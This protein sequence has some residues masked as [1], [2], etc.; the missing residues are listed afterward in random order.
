MLF[1]W[2]DNDTHSLYLCRTH[3]MPCMCK[4]A[5]TLYMFTHVLTLSIY[6]WIHKPSITYQLI[7]KL[8][9]LKSISRNLGAETQTHL[10]WVSLALCVSPSLSQAWLLLG[11]G[12]CFIVHRSKLNSNWCKFTFF[13]Q[14]RIKGAFFLPF[15][16]SPF[17]F[18]L[19]LTRP[20]VYLPWSWCLPVLQ[21]RIWLS[22]L[23]QG[24]GERTADLGLTS[25]V[26]FSTS[27]QIL[28]LWINKM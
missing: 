23:S 24:R 10:H 19:K 13:H 18:L 21:M 26:C 3:T 20:N 17:F 27:S 5:F 6:T 11:T 15:F 2:R 9:E 7:G 25:A 8:R 28:L 22:P 1:I 12:S 4:Y 16:L 14:H